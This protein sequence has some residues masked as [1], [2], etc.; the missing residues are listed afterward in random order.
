MTPTAK[1]HAI[2]PMVIFTTFEP[3]LAAFQ[4]PSID[5][6][7]LDAAEHG[8]QRSRGQFLNFEK[9]GRPRPLGRLRRPLRLAVFL[10]SLAWLGSVG[11]GQERRFNGHVFTTVPEGAG[12][13][14]P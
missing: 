10:S 11:A 8:R 4:Q 7:S 3:A 1:T 6:G 12:P 9:E 5:K 14:E 2:R 13:G